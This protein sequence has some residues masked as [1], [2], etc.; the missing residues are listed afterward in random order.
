MKSEL[1]IIYILIFLPILPLYSQKKEQI[2]YVIN[3]KHISFEYVFINPNSVESIN[4]DRESKPAEIQITTKEKKWKSISLQKFVNSYKPNEQLYLKLV[5]PIYLIDDQVVEYPD[6]IKIDSTYY[7]EVKI[8]SLSN[9]KDVSWECKNLT[10]V[11]IKL[12][13]TPV[14][15][16]RGNDLQIPEKLK[17]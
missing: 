10:L 15:H 16:V 8:Q 4:I 3:G 1:T 7:G 9:V 17:P 13:R 12:S 5:S 6:S 2:D 11:N 14:I